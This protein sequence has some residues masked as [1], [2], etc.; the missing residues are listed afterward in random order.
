M[1]ITT[2]NISFVW[3]NC[4]GLFSFGDIEENENDLLYFCEKEGS[5][6]L[7]K[8][9]NQLWVQ[10]K[11]GRKTKAIQGTKGTHITRD[12]LPHNEETRVRKTK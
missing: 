7:Y 1:H 5:C 3:I 9:M 11:K 4:F 6:L 12:T 8:I 10:T 2:A